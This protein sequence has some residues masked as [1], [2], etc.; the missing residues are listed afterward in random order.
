MTTPAVRHLLLGLTLWLIV[1]VVATYFKGGQAVPPA[2]RGVIVVVGILLPTLVYQV[3][4]PFRTV[5]DQVPDAT[6]VAFH[7]WRILAGFV[8]LSYGAQGLLPAAFVHNAGYG[9]I[10]VA[11]LV[12][13]VLALPESRRRYIGFHLFGLADFLLAVGTGLYFT[14]QH[15]PL[16]NNLFIFPLVLIPWYGVGLSGAS[17]LITLR[18]LLVPSHH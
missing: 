13:F 7:G 16:Q 17:H 3:Y 4:A 8:F 12:P 14:F 11:A 18:R 10:A 2:L 15:N 5:V 1:V 6:I 9:D